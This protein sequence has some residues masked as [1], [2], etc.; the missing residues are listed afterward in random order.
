MTT[1]MVYAS[2]ASAL[3]VKHQPN[4]VADCRGVA[5]MAAISR[6]AQKCTTCGDPNAL[7][8]CSPPLTAV[9]PEM[10][11][12]TTNCNPVSAAADEPTMT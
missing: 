8:S 4:D 2:A 3:M 1:W 6:T 11:A 10:S 7:I 9:L 5:Q 12:M